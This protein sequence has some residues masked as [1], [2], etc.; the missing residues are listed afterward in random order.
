[1]IEKPIV[2]NCNIS[3]KVISTLIS[4]I[5]DSESSETLKSRLF[6]SVWSYCVEICCFSFFV[7]CCKRVFAIF[8]EI[9]LLVTK[10]KVKAKIAII[11]T[12][13]RYCPNMLDFFIPMERKTP[14]SCI[15][16]FPQSVRISERTITLAIMITSNKPITNVSKFSKEIAVFL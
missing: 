8:P 5:A 2:Y 1:M 16:S 7:F 13:I 10:D 6:I 11:K 12:S 3:G 14:V 9:I 4:G 15:L